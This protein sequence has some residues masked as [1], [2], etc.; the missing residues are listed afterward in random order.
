M[1]YITRKTIFT[2][3]NH[4]KRKTHLL[5]PRLQMQ[6]KHCQEASKA[7]GYYIAY[8]RLKSERCQQWSMLSALLVNKYKMF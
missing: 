2:I 3:V 7:S 6:N 1:Y 4:G 8:L 5:K